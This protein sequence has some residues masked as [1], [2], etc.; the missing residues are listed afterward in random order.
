MWCIT[1]IDL[2]I[3]KNLCIPGIKPTW[4]WCM[5][6]LVCCW[7]PF[8]RILLRIFASM[9]ISDIGL[10]S[11]VQLLSRVRLFATP[12]IAARQASLSITN[13][14]S[15]PK[16]MSIELVMLCSHLILC[17]PLLLLPSIFPSIS[18][19]SNESTLYIRWPKSWS[20][21]TSPSNEYSGL[22][23]IRIDWFDLLAVQGLSRVFSNITVWKHEFFGAQPSIW[24]QLTSIYDY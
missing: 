1:L 2:W 16:L 24:V 3:L 17:H 5:I 9:F 20:F 18:V 6:F 12:W 4:S 22:I 14:R 21:S 7:I 23:S 8:A 15:S 10:F 11:S 13:S 19:F